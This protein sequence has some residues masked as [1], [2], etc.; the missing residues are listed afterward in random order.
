MSMLTYVP[1]MARVAR[2]YA[3]I[4]I[5][6]ICIALSVNLFLVP[7]EVVT[8]GV[9]GVAIMLNSLLGTPVGLITLLFNIPLLIAGFRYLG[10][11][12]FGIRTIY[13]T[14]ALSLAIDLLQP[15][16]SRYVS[17]PRDALLYTLYG[18]V[19]DGLGV[20]LVFRAQGTT[21]GIDIIARFLQR[22][23]GV[24]VGRSLLIM[25]ALVFAAAAYLY[26][27][28]KVLY[29]LLVAF[30]SGRVVDLVLEGAAYAR[31]AIIITTRPDQLRQ[32]I[33]QRLDR[34]VTQLQ[35]LGGYT[36]AT[37]TILLSVVAQSEISLLKAIVREHDPNAFVIISNVHEVL[38]EGFKPA[39]G[40]MP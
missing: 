5:G 26:S 25:N 27:L 34:G 17:A 37:R 32:A 11:F 7:N 4:T 39:D 33:L 10:G 40:A 8:G 21:G 24:A 1:R 12:V 9:T 15:L 35:G 19:L 14:V 31:Q 6:A 13:A 36:N 2:D 30:V 22:W 16:L 20:G 29:A 38:G 28:D 3:L 18:G 23:R